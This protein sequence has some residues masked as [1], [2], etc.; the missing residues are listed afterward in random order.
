MDFSV[1]YKKAKCPDGENGRIPFIFLILAMDN[2][3]DNP[4]GS[5]DTPQWPRDIRDDLKQDLCVFL[6]FFQ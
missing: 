2:L 4:E 6:S 5:L 1:T 3:K